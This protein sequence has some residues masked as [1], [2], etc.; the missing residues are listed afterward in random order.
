VDAVI[1]VISWPEPWQPK[2]VASAP[3]VLG[4]SAASGLNLEHEDAV[5]GI[6]DQLA[7]ADLVVLDKTDLIDS[8]ALNS[9]DLFSKGAAQ[10]CKDGAERSQ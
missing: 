7:C 3:E 5:A 4:S 1:T 6:E 8:S 9:M 2:D 10:S